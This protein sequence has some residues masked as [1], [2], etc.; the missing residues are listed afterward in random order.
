MRIPPVSISPLNKA[1]VGLVLLL[2]LA[3]GATVAWKQWFR[4]QPFYA[5]Y[6]RTGDLYFGRLTKFPSFSLRQVYLLQVNRENAENPLSVQRF[7]DVF[8]G[9]EDEIELNREDVVWLTELRDD[10]QL[11]NL[12]R[13]NPTLAAPALEQ[14][15][16][17]TP[18]AQAPLPAA[19]ADGGSGANAL[20]PAPPASNP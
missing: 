1:L 15:A 5:V 20:R 12:I 3:L 18:G 7:R 9:P 4:E 13:T 14:P 11:V 8:W 10:S 16:F 2:I 6:L 17:G 19:P